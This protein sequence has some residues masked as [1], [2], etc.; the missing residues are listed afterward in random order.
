[1]FFKSG[2]PCVYFS[3]FKTSVLTGFFKCKLSFRGEGESEKITRER[4]RQREKRKK[5]NIVTRNPPHLTHSHL[6]VVSLNGWQNERLEEGTILS[7]TS[8]KRR[9]S[10]NRANFFSLTEK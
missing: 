7:L 5:V 4:E 6:P 1:M 9:D 3:H 2:M 10:N 8:Q